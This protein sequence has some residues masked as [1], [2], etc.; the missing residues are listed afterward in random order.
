MTNLFKRL[1]REIRLII[2]DLLQM[3]KD[4]FNER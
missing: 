2:E 1:W 4:K 3:L